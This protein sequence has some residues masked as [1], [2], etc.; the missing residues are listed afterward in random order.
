[1]KKLSLYV[2]L[3]LM[4]YGNVLAEFKDTFNAPM[5]FIGLNAPNDNIHA[6]NERFKIDHFLKGIETYIRYLFLVK[7]Q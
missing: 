5:V 1:M 2:F 3:V 6:P 7:D 4:F